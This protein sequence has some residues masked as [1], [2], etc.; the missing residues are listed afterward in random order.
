LPDQP[1]NIKGVSCEYRKWKL[2]T[3]EQEIAQFD[4]GIMPLHDT[5]W[6][7]GKCSYKLLQYTQI[8]SKRWF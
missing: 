1:Y 2:E 3:Q 5:P 7:R 4:I 6:A 8:I